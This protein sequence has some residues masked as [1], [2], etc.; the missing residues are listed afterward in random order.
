LISGN[1][2]VTASSPRMAATDA[3]YR[4]PTSFYDSVFFYCLNCIFRARRSISAAGWDKRR[5]TVAVKIHRKKYYEFEYFF[6]FVFRSL[7][8]PICLTDWTFCLFNFLH[9]PLKPRFHFCLN[10]FEIHFFVR[11]IIERYVNL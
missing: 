8:R 4:Q 5:N 9:N 2:I 6:H 1:R 11:N 10:C 3:F 7:Q